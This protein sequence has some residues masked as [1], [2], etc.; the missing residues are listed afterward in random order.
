[1]KRFLPPLL[2][3]V[4]QT[5][6]L[7]AP[8]QRQDTLAEALDGPGFSWTAGGDLPWLP[9]ARD[10][11]RK[12]ATV[13]EARVETGPGE[14]YGPLFGEAE[15]WLETT[16]AGPGVFGIWVRHNKNPYVNLTLRADGAVAE[17]RMLYFYEPDEG[18]TAWSRLTAP[19]AP[20]THTVRVEFRFSVQ[21]TLPFTNPTVQLDDARVAPPLGAELL[22][23]IEAPADG[24]WI[25]G[26]GTELRVRTD[27][28][29]DGVDFLAADPAPPE[30]SDW[31]RRQGWLQREVTGPVTLSWRQR[32]AAGVWVARDAFV[33]PGTRQAR[34][35]HPVTPIALDVFREVPAPAAALSAAAEA[36]DLTFTFGGAAP[37]A[38]VQS[39]A[40]P[41]GVDAAW[42][43]VK[44]REESW[45]ETVV[46]GPAALSF[47]FAGADSSPAS[48]EQW[49]TLSWSVDGQELNFTPPRRDA[50]LPPG[51]HTV[52]WTARGGGYGNNATVVM[53]DRVTV[54][55]GAAAD[56]GEALDAPGLTWTTGGTGAG[57]GGWT[58][59][60][61]A[62]VPD[63]VDAALPPLLR[64]G[65]SAWVETTVT[66]PGRLRFLWPVGEGPYAQ[67]PAALSLG[68]DGL[69]AIR[70]HASHTAP[71][72]EIGPG[73]HTL[74]WTAEGRTGL[75]LPL[76]D[77][78][79]WTPL[80]AP[81]LRAALG[82]A[83]DWIFTAEAGRATDVIENEFP[84]VRLSLPNAPSAGDT[85]LRG[86]AGFTGPGRVVFLLKNTP[87]ATLGI[88]G[89]YYRGLGGWMP[90]SV[91]LRPGVRSTEWAV[92]GRSDAADPEPTVWLSRL[93]FEPSSPLSLPAALGYAGPWRTSAHAPWT[94]LATGAWPTNTPSALSGGGT[95]AV[96][97]WLETEVTGPALLSFLTTGQG[98]SWGLTDGGPRGSW[99]FT[100]PASAPVR[101]A[102]LVPPGRHTIR[103]E[104]NK[105]DSGVS[106][107]ALRP[108]AGVLT[109]SRASGETGALLLRIPRPE[110]WEITDI[111]LQRADQPGQGGVWI[112]DDSATLES[113][114]AATVVFRVSPE[115]NAPR[116]FYRAAYRVP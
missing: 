47:D 33:P 83:P 23:A 50:L 11:A 39:A 19:L 113:S 40:A 53:L 41:D 43:Q 54:T 57:A 67:P 34:W 45:L 96:P 65:E 101:R 66:G 46:T 14:H 100:Y 104:D 72:I 97:G 5:L 93:T 24:T 51:A 68:I 27:G 32:D 86:A 79:G 76:L 62:G 107:V 95:A 108:M 22:D 73:T 78:V 103:W 8:A 29:Y 88:G 1:M 38:G 94:G 9:V 36:D 75:R 31:D 42:T 26:G 17:E 52:R 81:P 21:G 10:G 69:F 89:E 114:D 98:I 70:Q 20:G 16:A 90:V 116:R 106:E 109:V 102:L 82:G 63:G 18:W 105:G 49:T 58:G 4:F 61:F 60:A 112:R 3:V 85:A 59:L 12:G 91:F 6:A 48:W 80:P 56:L 28:A 111:F 64:A 92:T 110:G 35:T 99:D 25:E 55:P 77:Q 2:L 84:A 71:E 37:W 13:A 74:R 15:A 44:P 115:P 30:A 87:N 7:H